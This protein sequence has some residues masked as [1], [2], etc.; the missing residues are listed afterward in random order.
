MGL[1]LQE[2]GAAQTPHIVFLLCVKDGSSTSKLCAT[3]HFSAETVNPRNS[4]LTINWCLIG[5]QA[6]EENQQLSL[7]MHILHPSF[8]HFLSITLSFF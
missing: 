2:P 6:I 8:S 3:S 5:L 7:M 1:S 4:I